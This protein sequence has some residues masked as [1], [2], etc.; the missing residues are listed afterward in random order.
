MPL[1]ARTIGRHCTRPIGLKSHHTDTTGTCERLIVAMSKALQRRG[2]NGIG[3]TELLAEA[4]AP[5][6][7]LY[8]HF[9]GGKAQFTVAAIEFTIARMTAGLDKLLARSPT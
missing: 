2:M 8:H 7:V 3:F 5:K 6:S 9:P 1:G 4:Q